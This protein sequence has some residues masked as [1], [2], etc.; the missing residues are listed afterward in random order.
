MKEIISQ[1]FGGERPLYMSKDLLLRDVTIHVGESSV[2]ECRNIEAEKCRFEGKYVF[3]ENDGVRCHDCFFAES[4]RSSVWYSRN[5][6]Y[7]DCVVEAPKMFRRAHDIDLENVKM[8]NAEETFWDCSKIRLRNVEID[9]ADYLFMH[10]EDIEIDNYRQNGN[11]SFQYAKNVVIRNA[12]INSKDSF[13]EAE[14]CTLYDCEINGEYLGW[15]SKG[16]KLVRCH[17]SGTQPLCYCE[18]LIL[19]DCSFGDDAD[20]AF[21]YSTIEATI[22]GK[23]VSIKNPTSGY[24][25]VD[26]AGEIIIDENQ[27][28]PADCKISVKRTH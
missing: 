4:A 25:R 19:E 5:I 27:R 28:Q 10:C 2:K 6:S 1:E 15:Y 3:W 23:I 24:I 12:V 9:N 7:K 21:E 14:D 18:N 11:Y 13:W 22:T 8:P 17:I 20:L 16:L 26:E